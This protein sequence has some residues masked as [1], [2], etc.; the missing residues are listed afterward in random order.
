MFKYTKNSGFKTSHRDSTCLVFQVLQPCGLSVQK[1]AALCAA[2]VGI[3]PFQ[4]GYRTAPGT[5]VGCRK[6]HVSVEPRLGSFSF[7]DSA[8]RSKKQDSAWSPYQHLCKTGYPLET[9]TCSCPRFHLP[10]PVVSVCVGPDSVL[11]QAT[12]SNKKWVHLTGWRTSF[13]ALV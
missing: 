10:I 7:P 9:L 3:M 11:T 2:C 4:G 8:C 1:Y 13:L 5:R 12:T 6:G